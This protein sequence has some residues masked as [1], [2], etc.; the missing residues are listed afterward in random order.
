MT[1]RDLQEFIHLNGITNYA[2][3]KKVCLVGMM[4]VLGLRPSSIG[5]TVKSFDGMLLSDV[6]IRYEQENGKYRIQF[7]VRHEKQLPGNKIENNLPFL[8]DE[9]VMNEPLFINESYKGDGLQA[10]AKSYITNAVKDIAQGI[11]VP[12]RMVSAKSP[13]RVSFV[14]YQRT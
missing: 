7:R 8:I 5:K 6:K 11:G 4:I 12:R 1:Y 3:L 14:K 10:V 2:V 9:T 13:R